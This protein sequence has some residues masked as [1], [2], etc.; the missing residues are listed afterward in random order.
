MTKTWFITGT[1]KGFGRVWAEAA[2]QR[3]D[4]VAATARNVESLRDL[5][6]RYGENVLTLELDVTNKAAAERTV[7]HV[8]DTFGR[9]DVIVNN[10]GYGLFGAIE[11]ISEQ[12]ARDQFEANLFGALW[13]TQA[14]LPY[15]RAQGSGHIIQVSSIGGV[16]AFSNVGMYNASKW[17]LEALS[18]ALSQEVQPFGIKVTLIEPIGYSTDW[19]GPSAKLATPQP[20]YKPLREAMAAR[21][22]AWHQGVP[23]ATGPVILKLV[24]ME[25]PPLRIF[26]GK[27][28][29][30]MIHAE[31]EKRLAEWDAFKDLSEEAD[32]A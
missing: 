7:R 2:L 12:E 32:G 5:K 1:S 21:R 8:Y 16:N 24:D 6:Q 31:Y 19:G 3:G 10:A 26:F 11:E 15:L 4:R 17:A 13:V 23:E 30:D 9:L 14:A 20:A 29:H 27:G 18:Q 25:Q 28:A 22:N